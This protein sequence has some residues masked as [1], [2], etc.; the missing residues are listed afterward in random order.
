V[1]VKSFDTLKNILSF[2]VEVLIFVKV[3]AKNLIQVQVGANLKNKKELRMKKLIILSFALLASV[4]THAQVTT[5]E[6]NPAQTPAITPP[7]NPSIGEL[8]VGTATQDNQAYMSQTD[9][10][11]IAHMNQEI[12]EKCDRHGCTFVSR[13]DKK[14]GWT[15]AFSAGVGSQNNGTGTTINLGNSNQNQNQPNYGVTLSYTNMSCTSDFKIDMDDYINNK[16]RAIAEREEGTYNMKPL[17][18]DMKFVQLLK[19]EIYKQLGQAGCLK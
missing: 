3:V 19:L 8:E 11:L 1:G 14:K 18:S 13:V 7:A 2:S 16:A 9:A 6:V 15:I 5:P 4:M 10:T 17:T 12:E